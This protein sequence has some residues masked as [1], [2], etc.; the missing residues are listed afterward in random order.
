MTDILETQANEQ[1]EKNF[2]PKNKDD[3]KN[4]TKHTHIERK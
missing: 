2:K 4:N 1:K 3:K